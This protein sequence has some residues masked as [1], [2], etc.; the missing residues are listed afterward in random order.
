M[1]EW[2]IQVAVNK[3]SAL[4]AAAIAGEPQRVTRRGRPSQF[5]VPRLEG[6]LP[7]K[8]SQYGTLRPT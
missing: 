6:D 7:P 3:F 4:V 2:P 8:S 5:R 1:A